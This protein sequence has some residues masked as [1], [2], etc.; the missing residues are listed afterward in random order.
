MLYMVMIILPISEFYEKLRY[1]IV[2][3]VEKKQ[4]SNI[5]LDTLVNV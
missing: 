4:I 2:N 5:T 1:I 3:G